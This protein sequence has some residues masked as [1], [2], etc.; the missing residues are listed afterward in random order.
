MSKSTSHADLE[1]HIENEHG[2]RAW[3]QYRRNM[4]AV[5]HVA[6]TSCTLCF[7]SNTA[8]EGKWFNI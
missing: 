1:K 4:S 3:L 5:L 2:R 8:Y 6:C 7:S